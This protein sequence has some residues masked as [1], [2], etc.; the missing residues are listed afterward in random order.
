[1]SLSEE[2]E[3]VGLNRRGEEPAAPGHVSGQ[4]TDLS[5]PMQRKK[6]KEREKKKKKATWQGKGFDFAHAHKSENNV[7][8]FFKTSSR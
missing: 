8:L 3:G 7:F 5:L 4:I 6:R 1:M 2:I